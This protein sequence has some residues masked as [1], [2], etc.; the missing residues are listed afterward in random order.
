MN[1]ALDVKQGLGRKPQE[2]LA[3]V[4]IGCRFPGGGDTPDAFWKLLSEG[5]DTLSEVPAGR[6]DSGWFN[7]SNAAVPGTMI[8][9]EGGF[10]S[11]KIDVLDADFFGISHR[12]AASI[13][14]QQRI[15]M[16]IIWEAL[17]DGGLPADQFSGAPVGVYVW[18]F[19][20]DSL[21]AHFDAKNRDYISSHSATSSTLGMLANRIS[22]LF[23]FRGPSLTIDT[24]CSSSLVALNYA[25]RDLWS[26]EC[27]IA[28]AA[29]VNIMMRPEFPIAMTKG[30]FLAQ[31]SRSKAFSADADG[32]GRGE[33][34]GVVV[35]KR[36]SEAQADGDRIY[37]IIRGIGVNQDGRTPGITVP[38]ADAQKQ[39]IKRVY[40]DF[41][42]D[43]A[44]VGYVEAHGTGTPVGDPIEMQALGAAIGAGR[45]TMSACTVGS[46][47]AN[48]GHQEAAAGIASTIKAALVLA[49]RQVPPQINFS[50]PNPN[51][52]FADHGFR[53]P[54]R[55]EDLPRG[56][57]PTCVS[58]NSFGFGGTN[59]HAVLGEVPVQRAL[60]TSAA[61]EWPAFTDGRSLVPVSA[62]SS[63]ALESLSTAFGASFKALDAQGKDAFERILAAMALRRAHGSHRL[64]VLAKDAPEAAAKLH[65]VS[66]GETQT[67]VFTG[68]VSGAATGADTR[69]VVFVFTGMGPQWWAMGR[70][71][72]AE[73]PVYRAAVIAADAAFVVHSGWSILGE[74]EVDGTASRMAT[75][76]IAQPANF[77]LQVGLVALWRSLGITPSAIIGHSVGE[78]AAAYAAGCLSLEDAALVSYHRSRC[79][80]KMAGQGKML[81]V[82]LSEEAAQ[83]LAAL[84]DGQVSVAAVNAAGSVALAGD[85]AAL[86]EIAAMLTEE[87]VFAKILLV[88]VAYHSYQMDP[89]E[90]ELRTVLADLDP[91]PPKVPLWSTVTGI[92]VEIA[93]HDAGYWWQN[94]RQTVRFCD[95]MADM[96][97]HGFDL[98]VE[99]G[100][101]P[102]LAPSIKQV[103]APITGQA[104]VLRSLYR[105]ADESETILSSQA[106]L[107]CNGA[108]LDWTRIH[109]ARCAHVAMPLYPWQRERFWFEQ[110]SNIPELVD[111]LLGRRADAPVPVWQSE[112]TH[113]SAGFLQDHKVDGALV[114]PGAGYVQMML[115]AQ[116]DLGSGNWGVVEDI[117]F[118]NA[119]VF[120]E[121]DKQVLRTEINGT[122]VSI[123]GR[124][125][126]EGA[127][128]IECA[129]GQLSTA[130]PRATQSLDLETLQQT[131]EAPIEIDPLYEMLEA[132]GLSYG[133]C[134]QGL[135]SL[136]RKGRKVLARI[137]AHA[138]IAISEDY[139]YLHPTMLDSAF[140]ALI[141][142]L[143][144]TDDLF[145]PTAIF[146]P[147]GIE[148]FQQIAPIGTEVWCVGEIE[149]TSRTTIVGELTFCDAEGAVLARVEG[150]KCQALH[151]AKSGK[152]D[153]LSG[154]FYQYEWRAGDVREAPEQAIGHWLV[155]GG[156]D[157]F[158]DD[159]ITG[160][161]AQG[162]DVIRA[163]SGANFEKISA[164]NYRLAF[165]NPL[166]WARLTA[167]LAGAFFD[168]IAFLGRDNATDPVGEQTC[169]ELLGLVQNIGANT[170]TA[171]TVVTLGNVISDKT[172]DVTSGGQFALTGL[173][174]VIANEY[175]A[176]EC[177]LIDLEAGYDSAMLG[178]LI[179]ELTTTDRSESEVSLRA[180]GRFVHRLTPVEMPAQQS[181]EAVISASDQPFEMEFATE[182]DVN[183]AR[184]V[185]TA[186]VAPKDD[187]VELRL[188]GVSLN[189][190][191][192][193]K[194]VGVLSDDII[195]G[196]F[197]GDAIGM[198]VAA[199]VIGVGRDVQNRKVGDRIIASV[200]NGCFR[201]YTTIKAEYVYDFPD[202]PDHEFLEL[203]GMPIAFVTSL[204]GLDRIARMQ[205]GEKVL[206]HSASGGVG[207]AAIQVARALGAEIYAT[208]GSDKKRD[209][210]RSLGVEHVFDSRSLYFVEDIRRVTDGAGVDVVF[211]FLPGEAQEKSVSLLAPFGRFIEIGKRDIDDNRGLGLRPF[212]RNLLFAAV[213][214]D[215]LLAEKP[216]LFKEML[217]E[218]W[219]GLEKGIYAPVETTIFPISEFAE[220]FHFM[221]RAEHIG[222]IVVRIEGEELPVIPKTVESLLCYANASYLVTGGFGGFGL[223]VADWLAH[224]GAGCIVLAGRSGATSDEAKAAVVALRARDID[225]REIRVD[226]SDADGVAAM[227]A[228]LSQNAPP[229]RGIY[230]AAAA[231]DDGLLSEMGE[232][233]FARAMGAKACGA[234]L[235]H[236]A[237]RDL[238]LDHFVLFSSVSA[239]IG[240]AGQGNYAAAN[241][242]LDGLAHLRRAQGLP[243]ISI[244]WGALAEVGMAARDEKVAAR[245]TQIGITGM[246]PKTAL[247]GL[248]RVLR[249]NATQVGVM[250]VD[251]S[252]WQQLN[253]T[254]AQAP[255]YQ[256]LMSAAAAGNDRASHLVVQLQE[257]NEAAQAAH[258]TGILAE[259]I[260]SVLRM[261]VERLDLAQPLAD[262]GIDSL[263]MVDVQLAVE[264]GIGLE[265]TVMELS[266]GGSI[267]RLGQALLMRLM[268]G[269]KT[270]D[271]AQAEVIAPTDKV[272]AMSNTEVDKM[273]AKIS[274]E[275]D[276]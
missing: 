137:E 256:D 125:A 117:A 94:V 129:V 150:F 74:M 154:L 59:A 263:M 116:H 146:I 215:R 145:D 240:N 259:Q 205:P 46:V 57:N 78:V 220:A 195:T 161:R 96:A 72:M 87:E 111:G 45:K 103:V 93:S 119:L 203:M 99:I 234:R 232:T 212:N 4:G 266:R 105:G 91:Q 114:F 43:P 104:E 127:S 109:G 26:G 53:V 152:S 64:A 249:N 51:I 38:N 222:K 258:L 62:R 241:T 1:K 169:L 230:H 9:F 204:Y 194:I 107:Y 257:M 264:E 35:L 192:I 178:G 163:Q 244:N 211:N 63:R 248:E 68:R 202:H 206:L 118:K 190:K 221:R 176:L 187:E 210:L 61:D 140:Q 245:L 120:E 143:D 179:N 216:A 108:D 170:G 81:A 153:P 217:H 239:L 198:E 98:F 226:I 274:R 262:M 29:G 229:L 135:K 2:P 201:G 238:E 167:P 3:I 144:T 252:R 172:T 131:F 207:L 136:Q 182:G 237:S 112:L 50:R 122:T 86:D 14:P 115:A 271:N 56:E 255:K 189:F 15:L 55:L 267:T 101:H 231:L 60:A 233:Q 76:E 97:E 253:S 33:G 270:S 218:V 200:P 164:G 275:E 123:N 199:E 250:D 148:K 85:S 83:E 89:L 130:R 37:A 151:Q 52:P 32:Y 156:S 47:K 208:A 95:A 162:R 34:G 16:E 138:S 12:E 84:Y 20:T 82:G 181:N 276:A 197:F 75:N 209:V 39:L 173:A 21:L 174:R 139:A 261:Q 124:R 184:F 180:D 106:A 66:T 268:G 100:P 260:A 160:L 228:D 65:G 149:Q 8:N 142:G 71:L 128:W 92:E 213:D 269:E 247:D 70:E 22:Y 110:E 24:A 236:H 121:N 132:R 214:I 186:R 28:L 23:D 17:E 30:R 102:V 177:R 7:D 219:L 18:G 25:C 36:L 243:G 242:Y 165:D 58:I 80:Q 67:G 168:G 185:E 49:K 223:E 273:L 193:L 54:T 183:S 126:G 251:W 5:V 225:V 88:E 188:H 27:S 171:L 158:S 175:P 6:W 254:A 191:D 40:S 166:D 31:N 157:G 147:V 133:P 77:I 227:M 44:D 159:V 73:S 235:L 155:V 90:D 113:T 48:I 10:L 11:E 141:A 224:Q 265:V 196:T 69:P 272:D 13:D 79:Q 41:G 246:A 42:I 19:T 134:F